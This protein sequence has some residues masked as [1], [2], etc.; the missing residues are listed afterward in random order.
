MGLIEDG[1]LKWDLLS[2]GCLI[3]LSLKRVDWLM[4]LTVIIFIVV[5]FDLVLIVNGSTKGFN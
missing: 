4:R 1:L 2:L 5:L 3:G